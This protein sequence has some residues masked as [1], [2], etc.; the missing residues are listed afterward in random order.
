MY[1]ELQLITESKIRRVDNCE[2]FLR[3]Y[4][5]KIYIFRQQ[6]ISGEKSG[7]T[8]NNLKKKTH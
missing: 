7:S 1:V 2:E 5:A 3:S 4:A 8:I 6:I